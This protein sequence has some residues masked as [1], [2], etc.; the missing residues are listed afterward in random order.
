MCSHCVLQ[1]THC[2]IDMW[3]L[4]RIMVFNYLIGNKDDHAKILLFIVRNG[5]WYIAPFDLLPSYGMNGYHTT[6]LPIRS[7]LP[8]KMCYL[9]VARKAG[10]DLMLPN[11]FWTI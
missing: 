9:L 11:I 10:L 7:L 4:F 5:V 1:L 8:T 3:K 6:L 2:E